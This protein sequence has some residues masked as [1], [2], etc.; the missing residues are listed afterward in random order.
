MKNINT[1]I[2]PFQQHS[3]AKRVLVA[4]HN[5]VHI[6]EVSQTLLKENVQVT[7]VTSSFQLNILITEPYEVLL[8][9]TELP[10]LELS[11]FMRGLHNLQPELPV[12]LMSSMIEITTF[13]RAQ[14]R[15]VVDY[16]AKPIDPKFL[17]GSIERA[18][19][20]GAKRMS[21]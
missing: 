17:I 5:N 15:G 21:A 20:L 10:G 12:I 14:L 8:I 4:D 11:E 18:M 7:A 3:H 16:M 13:S 2:I 1:K 9:D 19:R 6:K